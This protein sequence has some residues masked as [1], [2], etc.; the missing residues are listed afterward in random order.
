MSNDGVIIERRSNSQ[1]SLAESGDNDIAIIV[2]ILLERK[3]IIIGFFIVATF[4]S[5]SYVSRI[6]PQFVSKTE[7][8]VQSGS[9][10]SNTKAKSFIQVS[11]L[12]HSDLMPRF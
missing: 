2:N 9:N 5:T 3:W 6:Q 12:S 4:L 1:A 7:I 11:M 10:T 8:L